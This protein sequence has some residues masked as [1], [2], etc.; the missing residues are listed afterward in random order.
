MH[1]LARSCCEGQASAASRFLGVTASVGLIKLRALQ[2]NTYHGEFVH[3]YM[4]LV[5]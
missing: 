1:N 3:I 5:D 4:Q 2:E